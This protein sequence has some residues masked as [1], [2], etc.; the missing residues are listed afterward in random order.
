MADFMKDKPFDLKMLLPLIFLIF[1][2]VIGYFALSEMI[3]FDVLFNNR[4]TLFAWRDSNYLLV[5]IMFMSFYVFVVAFSLPGAVVMT[6]AGGFLFELFPGALFCV[7]GATMGA[8]VIFSAAKMG[9]GDMLHAKL[10]AKPGLIQKIETGLRENE[11]SF[12]FL[13]RLVP[14]IPFFLANLAPAFFGVRLR[15]YAFTTFFGIMPGSIVYTSV[16]Y[17][18]SDVIARGESPSLGVAFEQQILWPIFG[19]CLLALMPIVIKRFV[20][21][22]DVSQ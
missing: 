12:L 21:K 19:L 18:L 1:T 11:I 3:S 17:G 6:V 8:I 9:L 4:E 5:A 15:N 16:G 14:I 2:A 20:I 10:V 7:S 13:M 22:K